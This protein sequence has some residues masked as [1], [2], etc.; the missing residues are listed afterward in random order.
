MWTYFSDHIC[1]CWKVCIALSTW[2]NRF[3]TARLMHSWAWVRHG[4]Y[5]SLTGKTKGCCHVLGKPKWPVIITLQT[6]IIYKKWGPLSNSII[7]VW[8]KM[9]ICGAKYNVSLK[10]FLSLSARFNSSYNSE[11]KLI[12]YRDTRAY[13][14]CDC[15][16]IIF[17]F[18][19]QYLLP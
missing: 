16:Y 14:E 3:I 19:T 2:L 12:M 8:I 10:G 7:L 6:D 1:L 11:G 5:Y 18:Y 4:E 17:I 9:G 15:H 13:Q